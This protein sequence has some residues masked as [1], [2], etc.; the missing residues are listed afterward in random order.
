MNRFDAQAFFEGES[1]DDVEGAKVAHKEFFRCTFRNGKLAESR[2]ERCSFEA[3]TFIDCDLT[4]MVPMNSSWRGV[5]FK[6]CKLLGVDFSSLAVNPDVTFEGCILRYVVM[7]GVNLR[8]TRFS[9]CEMQ[10]AQLVESSF[11]DADFTGSDL[12]GATFSRCDLAG[13]DFSSARGVYF[14]PRQNTAKG[15]F[16]PVETAVMI[17]QAAGLRVAGHDDPPKRKRRA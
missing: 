2:W 15:A 1:F 6:Q 7:N 14:E 11:I 5:T 3:C 16:V 9:D 10:D 13:A 4:R 8:G 12:T 17:A